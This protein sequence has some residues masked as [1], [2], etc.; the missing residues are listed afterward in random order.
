MATINQKPLKGGKLI[1]ADI[2]AALNAVF[3]PVKG[4]HLSWRKRWSNRLLRRVLRR[5]LRSVLR[6]VHDCKQY[7]GALHLLKR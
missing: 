3:I 6:S 1:I 2:L 5:V 7:L 4:E